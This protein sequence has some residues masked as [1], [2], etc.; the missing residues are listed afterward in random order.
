MF[1]GWSEDFATDK[2]LMEKT[3]KD[4]RRLDPDNARTLSLFG[5]SR[6]IM[7]RDY[8][9]SEALLT[10]A[11]ESAPNDAET[12]TW[13][14]PTLA[15]V[16]RTEEAIARGQRALN[17]SPLDPFCFRNE[18]FLSLAYYE[19]DAFQDSIFWG[20]R[21]YERNPNY[22]SNIRILISGLVEVGDLNE[23]KNLAHRLN[24]LQPQLSANESAK[25][26]PFLSEER[27]QRYRERLTLA[28]I[29]A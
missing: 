21:C 18:C 10:K 17:L 28:G 26:M 1:Q 19:A 16:G 5:H 4:A 20:Q 9:A 7:E 22:T 29:P 24:A 12:L 2:A 13:T 14:I 3:T 6:T 25:R 15:Y 11:Y 8:A 23:A 27:R